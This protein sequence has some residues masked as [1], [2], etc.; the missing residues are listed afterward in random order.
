MERDD[1]A[2]GAD[3][4]K[5]MLLRREEAKKYISLG[6]KSAADMREQTPK[7]VVSRGARHGLVTL[8]GQGLDK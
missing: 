8:C 6:D 4:L 1:V 2:R 3:R 5:E 7:G